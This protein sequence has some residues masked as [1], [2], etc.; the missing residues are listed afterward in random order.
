MNA[1]TAYMLN[2]NPPPVKAPGR[3][4]EAKYAPIGGPIMKQIA[5]AIPTC[6]NAFPRFSGV[7][8]SEIMALQQD[9]SNFRQVMRHQ[10]TDIASC[11][12]PS[13]RPPMARESM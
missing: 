10:A 1:G 13:L 11:T 9:F 6:A 8:M 7:V 4:R 2:S 5:K 3:G 12:L